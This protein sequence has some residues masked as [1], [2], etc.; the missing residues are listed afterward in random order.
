MVRVSAVDMPHVP[1]RDLSQEN[2]KLHGSARLTV[3]RSTLISPLCMQQ[4]SVALE[5]TRGATPARAG[6]WRLFLGLCFVPG[7]SRVQ[8][9]VKRWQALA[10]LVALR[11]FAAFPWLSR[12][13]ARRRMEGKG[14]GRNR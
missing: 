5:S 14:Y 4:G 6:D 8:M 10:C 9:Q 12:G 1:V 11:L 3:W 7:T 2:Q 13:D